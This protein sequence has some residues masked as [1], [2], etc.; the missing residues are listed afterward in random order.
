MAL[1][2]REVEAA[3]PGARQLFLWDDEVRGFGLRVLPTG[4]KS[5]ILQYRFGTRTRR[6]TLGRHG[7]L[8]VKQAREQARDDLVSVRKGIDPA[9]QRR[10]A[11]EAETMQQLAELYL[12]RHARPHK[13]LSSIRNDQA[14]LKNRILPALGKRKVADVTRADVQRLHHAMEDTPYGA[15]RA[16]ALLSKM[17]NLAERWDIRPDNTNPCRHVERFKEQRRQRFLSTAELARLG[18][19][20]RQVERERVEW[21][22]VVPAIRLL[23]FTGARLNEILTLKWEHVDVE[24]GCLHLSDSKTG[25]KDIHLS[26]GARQLLARLPRD[27]TNPHVISGRL[28]G[29]HLVGLEKPWRRIRTRASLSGVRLHDLR[30]TYA[31]VAAATGSSIPIIGALLGHTQPQ[32]T[33]R[34]THLA[35]DPLQDAASKVGA[36]LSAALGEKRP[37]HGRTAQLRPPRK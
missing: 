20:L 8:T 7:V 14:I 6:L 2:K 24:A 15:N 21:H 4:I 29:S 33:A 30:H 5:Y 22:S 10:K 1:T 36:R 26:P 32:T 13:K 34:Y 16:L 17:M 3:R 18:E 37:D 35:A 9:A 12:D 11:R 19:V 25:A 23:L 28:A 27:A 31:S